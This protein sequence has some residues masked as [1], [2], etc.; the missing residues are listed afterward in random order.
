MRGFPSSGAAYPNLPLRHPK[1]GNRHA[2]RRLHC[3]PPSFVQL[4]SKFDRFHAGPPLVTRGPVLNVASGPSLI[5]RLRQTARISDRSADVPPSPFFEQPV[6]FSKCL[7]SDKRQALGVW[8]VCDHL[9]LP[10]NPPV[11]ASATCRSIS[12]GP[13]DMAGSTTSR[14]RVVIPTKAATDHAIK[15]N[16]DRASIATGGKVV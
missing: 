11:G 15:L 5:S 12:K 9:R 13:I 16:V 1:S 14:P 6:L 10:A 8:S 3:L 4:R 2:D 7:G